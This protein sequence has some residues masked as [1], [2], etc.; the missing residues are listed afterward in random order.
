MFIN[1]DSIFFLFKVR[2]FLMNFFILIL[3]LG[4]REKCLGGSKD[5]LGSY[6]KSSLIIKFW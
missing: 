2:Y 6:Y 3:F 4:F 5:V 1:F